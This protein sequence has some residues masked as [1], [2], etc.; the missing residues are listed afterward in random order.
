MKK[1]LITV[2]GKRYEV[3][4]EV[5]QDDLDRGP[6]LAN[7]AGQQGVGQG[8]RLRRRIGVE[9]DQHD[10]WPSRRGRPGHAGFPLSSTNS[11]PSPP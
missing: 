4:V 3:D 1:L 10:A 11:A 9:G 7:V 5:V 8:H 2:N 6:A